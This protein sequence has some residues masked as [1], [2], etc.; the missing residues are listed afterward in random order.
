[1]NLTAA[2]RSARGRAREYFLAQR[3]ERG[4]ELFW[5]HSATHDPAVAPG[6][7][8]YGTWAGVFGTLL[9]DGPAAF[10]ASAR[11]AVQQALCGFQ[12]HDGSFF[13][14][15][16]PPADLGGH[17]EEYLAFHCTNYAWGALHALGLSPQ[18]PPAFLAPLRSADGLAA[19]L[20]ARD[21]TRSWVEGNN[22]VNL[23]SF[24]ILLAE[25]GDL[26]A[27][28]RLDELIHWHDRVQHAE[29]GLW[30]A[31]DARDRPAL[32]DALAGAAH[33]LHLYYHAG[34][35]VPHP[36]AII[37]SC[38]R[39]GYLGISSACI[40]LDVIELLCNLRDTGYRRSEVD[41]MLRRYLVELLQVQNADGG[42]CDNYVTPHRL[43]GHTTP[44]GRSVTWVTWFRL[45]A[46]GMI[47]CTHG[48]DEGARWWFRDT[49]GSG[50]F[51]P[52][53][54]TAAVGE[55]APATRGRPLGATPAWLALR[56][57]GRWLRQR[58]LYSLRQ[59]WRHAATRSD[60]AASR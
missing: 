41:R 56:R 6:H 38:L 4:D 7:L 14:P 44:A 59:A 11:R 2:L 49:V 5:R 57:S 34:R 8:L 1:V 40:D 42:F 16:L 51:N 36:T 29:T 43:Y 22:C 24:F 37:D 9:I 45:A 18:H 20:A 32:I 3:W 47:A 15:G 58:T 39:L 33:S 23:A 10:D 28:Q 25:A 48:E 17:S 13:L 35:P 26:A 54:V 60:R 50:Y 21:L 46:I 53:R 52:A 30:H 12:R 31:G 27:E 55:P 19:W